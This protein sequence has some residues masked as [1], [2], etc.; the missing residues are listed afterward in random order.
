MTIACRKRRA[1][2]A[3]AGRWRA[4][5]WAA[6]CSCSRV[7]CGRGGGTCARARGTPR[8]SGW[9][10][11][12]ATRWTWRASAW[13]GPWS[14]AW[15]IRAP[16]ACSRR[17][18]WESNRPSWVAIKELFARNFR[19]IKALMKTPI[20]QPKKESFALCSDCSSSFEKRVVRLDR[21]VQ[22]GRRLYS[23]D[24][25]VELMALAAS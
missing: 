10:K 1:P 15:A 16:L 21:Q 11:A 22:L 6:P 18:P 14:S 7:A 25:E 4:W 13:P 20:F 2:G 9:S 23:V 19:E 5:C 24:L 8:P 12:G 3:A 17:W